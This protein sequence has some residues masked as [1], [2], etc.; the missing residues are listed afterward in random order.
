MNS[1]PI[2]FTPG[3]KNVR[4]IHSQLEPITPSFGL[5]APQP[6]TI[7]ANRFTHVTL[8]W[9]GKRLPVSVT[10]THANVEAEP[11]RLSTGRVVPLAW[12]GH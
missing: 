3:L 12:P 2:R 6:I 10:V 9:P 5:S 1:S 7:A 4:V 11:V 8:H